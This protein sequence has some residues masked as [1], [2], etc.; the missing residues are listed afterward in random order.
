MKLR[1]MKCNTEQEMTKEFYGKKEN[2][3]SWHCP[4]CND[5]ISQCAV[6]EIEE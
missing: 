6:K 1:C 4:Y 3:F 2:E 5:L